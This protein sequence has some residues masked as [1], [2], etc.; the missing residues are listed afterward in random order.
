[1]KDEVKINIEV[2][3]THSFWRA[4][5]NML[6]WEKAYNKDWNWLDKQKMFV[7]IQFPDVNSKMTSPYIYMEVTKKEEY[8]W[9]I[10]EVTNRRPRMPSMLDLFSENWE[11]IEK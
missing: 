9:E 7:A 10:R 6:D 4:F 11:I 5:Q 1:M 8:D 3:Y 2:N